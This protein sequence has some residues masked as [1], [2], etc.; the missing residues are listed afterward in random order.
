MTMG[1]VIPRFR[2][3]RIAKGATEREVEYRDERDPQ[4]QRFYRKKLIHIIMP[5]VRLDRMPEAAV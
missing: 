1:R 4:P 3:P 2:R 5:S